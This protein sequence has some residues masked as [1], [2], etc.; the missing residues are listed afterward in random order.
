MKFKARLFRYP[1]PGGWTFAIHHHMSGEAPRILFL[2]YWG[3]GKAAELA[4][5]VK[6]ALDLT[7]WEKEGALRT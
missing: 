4:A 6:R 3:R 1:G 2:H 5:T 7:A